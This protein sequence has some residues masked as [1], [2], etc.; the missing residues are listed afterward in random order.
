[1]GPSKD[2]REEAADLRRQQRARDAQAAE[3]AARRA[4]EAEA[5][6]E[7]GGT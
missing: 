2:K 5:K 7:E 6:A 3:E 4:R 1:M